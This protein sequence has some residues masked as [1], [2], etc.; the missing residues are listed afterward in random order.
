[1]KIILFEQSGRLIRYSDTTL[2]ER[3]AIYLSI[4]NR[5]LVITGMQV[6]TFLDEFNIEDF[7]ESNSFKWFTSI[8]KQIP[9]EKIGDNSATA[10]FTLFLHFL[11]ETIEQGK[12]NILK[13]WAYFDNDDN[14]I[15]SIL[16][17]PEV[18]QPLLSHFFTHL[19]NVLNTIENLNEL[20]K[21]RRPQFFR[22]FSLN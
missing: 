4:V 7:I 8:L 11:D 22:G 16:D 3:K 2:A 20:P 1:M 19:P 14:L 21:H 15:M 18:M 9:K 6:S 12:I 10:L 13:E 17:S 5:E